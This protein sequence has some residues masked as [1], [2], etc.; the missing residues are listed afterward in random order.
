MSKVIIVVSR[1]IGD[2]LPSINALLIRARRRANLETDS[3]H[4]SLTSLRTI[5]LTRGRRGGSH[6][7]AGKLPS[8]N[9]RGE[10]EF[11]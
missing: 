11:G 4:G 5:E 7:T 6:L 8:R 3:F 1:A 10:T 2:S 9:L